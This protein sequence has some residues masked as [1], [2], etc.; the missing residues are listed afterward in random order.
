MSAGALIASVAAC[1]PIGVLDQRPPRYDP[2]TMAHNAYWPNPRMECILLRQTDL[3]ATTSRKWSM[4][5]RTLAER[6]VR[7]R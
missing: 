6:K 4:N 5:N 7:L 2:T 3:P 1:N